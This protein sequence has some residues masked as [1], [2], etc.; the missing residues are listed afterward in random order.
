MILVF[1]TGQTTE[2]ALK[3]ISCWITVTEVI[4]IEV[5]AETNLKAK[6]LKTYYEKYQPKNYRKSLNSLR[7]MNPIF[8]YF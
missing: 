1:T 8:I 3:L 4:P 2:E 7:K 6:S 5:K